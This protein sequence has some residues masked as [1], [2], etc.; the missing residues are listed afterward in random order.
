MDLFP[1]CGVLQHEKKTQYLGMKSEAGETS[2]STQRNE[3]EAE[4]TK[5]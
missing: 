3:K 4:R 2:V 1:V 5:I